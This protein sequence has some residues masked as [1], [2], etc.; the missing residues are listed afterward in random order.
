MRW[1]AQRHTPLFSFAGQLALNVPKDHIAVE[2][3][4]RRFALPSQSKMP[5]LRRNLQLVSLPRT[6]HPA[7]ITTMYRLKIDRLNMPDDFEVSPNA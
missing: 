2:K 6:A 3:R 7:K 1:E 5:L 4:R